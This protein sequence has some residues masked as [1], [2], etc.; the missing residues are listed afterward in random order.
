M[1][2][3]SDDED[4]LAAK[5]AALKQS[6]R[7][8]AD[9]KADE[10]FRKAAE[11]DAA[12]G[13][14]KTLKPKGSGWLGGWFSRGSGDESLDKKP[15]KARLGEE[16]SFYYDP[17]L[18]KWVNKKASPEEQ[19]A[20]AGPT[21]PPPKGPAPPGMGGPPP[22]GPSPLA[23]PPMGSSPTS[24]P[25]PPLGPSGSALPAPPSGPASRMASPASDAP[26]GITPGLAPPSR[27]STGMSSVS[28]ASD[29]D[30]LL[31]TEGRRGGT[32][33]RKKARGY[34]DVMAK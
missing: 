33:R 10:A 19:T 27:P 32:M 25:T 9:R 31:P 17:D 21:P 16:N 26:A 3:L 7:S 24:H 28:N 2:D 13:K 30:D 8:E 1:L 22:R 6:Q 11:A 29:I 20:S 18:K 34:V 23:G 14:E 5:A 15:I 12:R 4:E